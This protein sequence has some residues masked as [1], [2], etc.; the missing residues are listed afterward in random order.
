MKTYSTSSPAY[1][2][3]QA[4]L[5]ELCV[6]QNLLASQTGSGHGPNIVYETEGDFDDFFGD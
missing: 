5:L 2:A 1:E 4:E 6:E 3:P